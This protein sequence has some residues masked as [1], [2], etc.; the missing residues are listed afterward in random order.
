MPL[1]KT[2]LN[3]FSLAHIRAADLDSNDV[4]WQ[5]VETDWLAARHDTES[6]AEVC[7][8]MQATSTLDLQGLKRFKK[9]DDRG[10]LLQGKACTSHIQQHRLSSGRSLQR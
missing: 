4:P 6:Y 9:A 10:K 2:A 3:N 8:A 1:S 5:V 7:I